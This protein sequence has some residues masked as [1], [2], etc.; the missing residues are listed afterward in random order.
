MEQDHP[1]YHE[2]EAHQGLVV[3]A[4][5]GRLPP[6][7]GAGPPSTPLGGVA[8]VGPDAAFQSG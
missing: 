3:V 8:Q 4:T 7:L 5:R 1:S 6:T 2:P